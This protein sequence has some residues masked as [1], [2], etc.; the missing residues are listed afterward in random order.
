ML[1]EFLRVS[2]MATLIS[3]CL[4]QNVIALYYTFANIRFLQPNNG[5]CLTTFLFGE[6][7]RKDTGN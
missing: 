5:P 4:Q 1:Y 3:K 2:D 6:I 7:F